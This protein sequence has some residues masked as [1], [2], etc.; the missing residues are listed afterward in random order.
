MYKRTRKHRKSSRKSKRQSR[1]VLPWWHPGKDQYL[2]TGQNEAGLIGENFEPAPYF[3]LFN[4]Q[5]VQQI[6]APPPPPPQQQPIRRVQE[7]LRIIPLMEERPH[8]QR[9]LLESPVEHNKRV[10]KERQQR[11][12]GTMSPRTVGLVEAG[13]AHLEALR[14]PSTTSTDVIPSSITTP[15]ASQGVLTG[16]QMRGTLT[17]PTTAPISAPI[18]APTTTPTAALQTPERQYLPT[19]QT[20]ENYTS[21]IMVPPQASGMTELSSLFSPSLQRQTPLTLPSTRNIPQLTLPPSSQ[22]LSFAELM[23]IFPTAPTTPVS[24]E[25]MDVVTSPPLSQYPTI[26]SPSPARKFVSKAPPVMHNPAPIDIDETLTGVHLGQNLARYSKKFSTA[27]YQTFRQQQYNRLTSLNR[28]DISQVFSELDRV[29]RPMRQSYIEQLLPSE[30]DFKMRKTYN[31]LKS[32]PQASQLPDIYKEVTNKVIKAIDPA[33]IGNAG[34][35]KSVYQK[36]RSYYK[37]YPP[38]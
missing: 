9:F 6:P 27:D 1:A 25:E 11:Q 33:L 12:R 23:S 20:L 5:P 8:Q 13:R 2:W 10:R 17:A 28:P 4:P 18:S 14:A 24:P 7:P 31:Q 30:I 36:V 35:T 37:S 22:Q 38:T 3:D 16:Y 26:I 29:R 21:R 32:L 19:R 34:L 15:S